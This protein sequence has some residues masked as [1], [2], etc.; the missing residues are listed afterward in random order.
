MEMSEN[1][2]PT[3]LEQ[4]E[5][6]PTASLAASHAKTSRSRAKVLDLPESAAAYGQ[7]SPVLLASFDPDTLSWRTSQRCLVEGWET[8]SEP[9]PR[10]GMM[11]SGTAYQLAP[12][13]PLTDEI[14]SGYWPTPTVVYTREDWT[15]E[16]IAARQAEVKAE[17]LAKGKHHT[18]NGFGLNLA[19]AVRMWPT[20]NASSNDKTPCPTDARL[21]WEGKPRANGAKVQARLRDAAAFWPTPRAND[22]EKRGNINPNDPRNGLPAAVLKF[23]TPTRSMHKGSSAGAMT[24]SSGASRLNDRLDFAVEQGNIKTGRLNPLWVAW[25]MG[26]PIEWA[27]FAPTETP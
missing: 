17:T 3:G 8:F 13:V 4:T 10:S 1:S 23:P 6:F 11:R 21:A 16:R 24:R 20:P 14:A 18:G 26:F 22:A 19:Q 2:L 9:W 5:L 25:L 27:S 7:S 12:L 15:P